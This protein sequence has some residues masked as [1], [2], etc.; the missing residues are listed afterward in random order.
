MSVNLFVAGTGSDVG[1]SYVTALII[2]KLKSLGCECGYFKAT[3][4]RNGKDRAEIKEFSGIEQDEALM[5][6]Y[7]YETEHLPY[8][9][10]RKENKP[11]SLD[12][13]KEAFAKAGDACDYLTM[14]G[15]SGICC[16]IGE[17]LMMEDIVMTLGLP[18]III[19]DAG[20]GC[21]NSVVLTASYM[22]TRDMAVK[23]I[24]LNNYTKG[25]EDC[26]ENAK[27]CEMLTGIPV[28]ATVAKG[29]KDL[30]IDEDALLMLYE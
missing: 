18:S 10:G 29:D 13:I 24:I 3:M 7:I 14:E 25:D 16:P 17:D 28:I 15:S 27:M 2:K 4:S 30:T 9:A 19:A 1:K 26:E 8:I 21:I 23:G 6:P 11:A 5:C 22:I 20:K 12:V